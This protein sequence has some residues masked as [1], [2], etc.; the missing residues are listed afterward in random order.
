M[1]L[2][3]SEVPAD[4]DD[5]FDPLARAS[6]SASASKCLWQATTDSCVGF[7]S[8]FSVVLTSEVLNAASELPSKT[9]CIIPDSAL[10]SS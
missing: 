1:D 7:V 5:L 3:A 4:E 2:E 6:A 10:N 8:N 9:P